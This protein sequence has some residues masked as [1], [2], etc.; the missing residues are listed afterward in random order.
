MDIITPKMITN[1]TMFE[2]YDDF[3]GAK[4]F[5]YT[6]VDPDIDLDIVNMEELVAYAAKVS[7]PSSS[8]QEDMK[9]AQKLI[10]YLIKH[11]HWSPLEMADA[12]ILFQTTR[13]ISHQVI[14]HRSFTFQ[15]F[16]QRYAEALTKDDQAIKF[17][18]SEARLQDHKNRQN[19]TPLEPDDW[20][21][22]RWLEIQ[23]DVARLAKESYKEAIDMGL[24]KE[25][26]RKILPEGLT[27]TRAFMKGS[28]RSWVHYINLRSANGTQKEHIQLAKCIAE[29]VEKCFP[30]IKEFSNG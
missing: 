20:R 5:A 21:Q 9:N 17:V 6:Q 1:S 23:E 25:V 29:A 8:K 7:N 24:A 16:S 14:R 2:S 18:T 10:R 19:S 12:V 30:M 13:D 3:V 11:E 4:L 27:T 15:E 28:I 26:A 22:E